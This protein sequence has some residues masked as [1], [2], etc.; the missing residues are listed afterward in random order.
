MFLHRGAV[1]RNSGPIYALV[2]QT[3]TQTKIIM[4]QGRYK[5]KVSKIERFLNYFLLFNLVLMLI[6]GSGLTLGNYLFNQRIFDRY[7]YIFG[8]NTELNSETIATK[9]F[10]S[11]YL[12]LNQYVPLDLVISIEIAKLIATPFFECDVEMIEIQK[13]PSSDGSGVIYAEQRFEAHTLNLH[14][15]LAEIEYIFADKTGTLTQNELVFKEMSVLNSDGQITKQTN[16]RMFEC[17]NLNHDCISVENSQ[18]LKYSGQSVDEICLLDMTKNLQTHGFFK[19][20]TKEAIYVTTVSGQEEEYK[21][22][23]LFPFTSERKAMSI[24]VEDPRGKMLLFT[25]G[26]DSS[27]LKMSNGHNNEVISAEVERQACKGLR[28][29]VFGWKE[30]LKVDIQTITDR[31]IENGLELLGV[32]GVEDLL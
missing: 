20:R 29:L 30:V 28:T 1:L 32:T 27:L 23:K 8:E 19:R 5:F 25:K 11:F 26:A 7:T 2:T 3:G 17:I 4:N 6:M 15:D 18:G 10:F 14:E 31:E 13:I 9:A 12:M 24:L 16:P 22:L 21:I